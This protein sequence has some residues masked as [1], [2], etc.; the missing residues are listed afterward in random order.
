VQTEQ[1]H[2]DNNPKSTRAR[3]RTLPQ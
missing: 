3:K 1:L 2:C